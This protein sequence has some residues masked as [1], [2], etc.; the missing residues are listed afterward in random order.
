MKNTR[1]TEDIILTGLYEDPDQELKPSVILSKSGYSIDTIELRKTIIEL[2][3]NGLIEE[4]ELWG[5][6]H[7]VR[8]TGN[9]VAIS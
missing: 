9:G 6:E 3:N 4:G 5:T 1:T 2:I 7:F 8:L